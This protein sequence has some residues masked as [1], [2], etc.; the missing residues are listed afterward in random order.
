MNTR[1]IVTF[2]TY[3]WISLLACSLLAIRSFGDD[4]KLSQNSCVLEI[5]SKHS[6][7]DLIKMIRT[8]STPDK[9]D[10][11][12][13]VCYWKSGKRIF[14]IINSKKVKGLPKM[15]NDQW[16][17]VSIVKLEV[18]GDANLIS[19]SKVIINEIP[20]VGDSSTDN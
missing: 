7:K 20:K 5:E 16:L 11:N 4:R 8:Q 10:W 2:T 19:H 17:Q 9:F 1:T 6:A 15:T 3:T 12:D 13:L 14:L 18:S